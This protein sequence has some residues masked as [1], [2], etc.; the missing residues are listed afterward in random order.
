MQAEPLSGQ[1]SFTELRSHAKAYF[2]AV[3]SGS[4]VRVTR[5]GLPIAE[6]VPIRPRTPAWKRAATP[7]KL[8]GPSLSAELLADREASA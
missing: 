3:E 4:T 1:V 6:I 7:I 8:A 2:D 5:N